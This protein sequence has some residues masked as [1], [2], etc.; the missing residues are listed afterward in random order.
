MKRQIIISSTNELVR[1]LPQRI[2]YISSDGN[3][4][5]MVLHDKTEHL[6]T[7]N[8]S[9]FQK[10]IETQLKEDARTF[11][12]IGKSLIINK[13]Y[14]YKINMGKQLLVLSD[15]VLN[16]AFTLSASKEALRQLKLL[17]ETEITK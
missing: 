11:I 10:I 1:V 7:F 5:T 16:Q 6:F 17:L 3:Y 4:S 8:L 14:I 12:R 2:V 9:H 13:E 15:M